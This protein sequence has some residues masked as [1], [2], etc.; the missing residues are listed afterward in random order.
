MVFRHHPP[1]LGPGPP[2]DKHLQV[3]L[4]GSQSLQGVLADGAEPALID[5]AEQAVFQVGIAQLTG[6]VVAEYPLDLRGG[7]DLADHIE[8]R[9][10]VQGVA[11]LLE[12]LSSRWRTRPSIVLVATKLK[13]RQSLCL[14]VTV[15]AAHPLLQPVG[16]PG[17]VV[18]EEDV[19]ALQVDAL[20]GRLGG[21]Q[22]LD[23]AVLELLLGVQPRARFVAGARS[24]AAVDAADA[25]APVKPGAA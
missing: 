2:L 17:N 23:A 20:A 4:F 25:E 7:Q 21:N 10:I 24:H 14:A 3:E 18:V 8:D 5:V 13:M 22:D 15:D 19:A 9:V 16:V 11:D 6:V 12:L 1:L